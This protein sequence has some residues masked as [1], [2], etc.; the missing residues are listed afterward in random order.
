M[1]IEMAE[2]HLDRF[3]EPKAPHILVP[4]KRGRA[5]AMRV[6][7][8]RIRKKK[9]VEDVILLVT[10]SETLGMNRGVLV[11]SL[12][13]YG[14]EA[15]PLDNLKASRLYMMGL[16]MRVAKLLVREIEKLFKQ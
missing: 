12:I 10:P 15:M 8:K 5:V 1:S 3:D 16:S 2:S 13:G 4:L 7:D 6:N 9:R 11:F 14:C